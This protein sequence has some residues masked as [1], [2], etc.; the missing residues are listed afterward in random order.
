MCLITPALTKIS[1]GR[2]IANQQL[3][4]LDHNLQPVPKGM[5]GELYIG[6]IGL[7]RGYH[8]RPELTA[9][10]FLPNPFRSEPGARIYKT[11]DLCRYLEDGNL[12]Y[13]GRLDHQVKIRGFRVELG[14]VEAQLAA[15]STVKE[16]VV[17][18]REDIAGDKR[19]VAY[20]TAKNGEPP[21]VSELREWLQAKLPEHMIPSAFVTL[22]QFPLTPN[23]KVR[24]LHPAMARH[25]Q[26]HPLYCPEM[27]WKRPSLPFGKKCCVSKASESRTVSLNWVAIPCC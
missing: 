24:C 19:L 20:L 6:G 10:R 17:M 5:P 14:E 15:H 4:I 23:G 2:P 25:L 22:E 8:K 9:E 27:K 26:K 12:E 13:L 3:Y 18:A 7:A 11:G 16:V 1:I 21:K